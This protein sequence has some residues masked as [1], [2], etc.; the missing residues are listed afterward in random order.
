MLVRQR[1]DF[2]RGA[3]EGAGGSQGEDVR[4]PEVRGTAPIERDGSMITARL[5]ALASSPC[6]RQFHA[7]R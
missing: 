5:R 2:A 6:R 1:E 4:V 3:G 7:I